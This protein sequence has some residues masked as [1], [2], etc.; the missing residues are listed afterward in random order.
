MRHAARRPRRATPSDNPGPS[1]PS[2]SA[3]RSGQLNSPI[4]TASAAGVS[5]SSVKPCSRSSSSDAMRVHGTREHVPD[6]DPHAP[7][8]QRVGTL[9]RRA[10]RRR[11][12]TRPRSGTA[13]PRFS[14][15]VELFDDRDRSAPASTDATVGSGHRSPDAT[16]PRCRS[17]PT[18]L[19]STS[20]GRRTP[21][22]ST[23]IR[24]RRRARRAGSGV[25]STE[26]TVRPDRSKRL[27]DVG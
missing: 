7:P 10:A 5:A 9:A 11:S 3:Y 27:D 20:G 2:S 15:S 1:D 25:T 14:W 18:T 8:V 13:P 12:R 4:D 24:A 22:A 17:N 6:R 26:R 23:R 21:G 19:R 16:A